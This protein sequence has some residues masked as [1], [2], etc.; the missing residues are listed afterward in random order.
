MRGFYESTFQCRR[1]N[2]RKSTRTW[3]FSNGIRF[4]IMIWAARHGSGKTLLFNRDWSLKSGNP[5]RQSCL[6]LTFNNPKALLLDRLDWSIWAPKFSSFWTAS[7]VVCLIELNWSPATSLVKNVALV[8]VIEL[9]IRTNEM[10]KSFIE[11]VVVLLAELR[12]HLG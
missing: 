9:V 12:Q 3:S 8:E 11:S 6:C 2:E 1:M 4:L 5:W 7:V 10:V